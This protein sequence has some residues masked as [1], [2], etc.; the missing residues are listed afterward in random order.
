LGSIALGDLL[1]SAGSILRECREAWQGAFLGSLFVGLIAAAFSHFTRWP[2]SVVTLTAIMVLVPRASAILGV[3][4]A[5]SSGLQAGLHA[6]WR[7]F[8]GDSRHHRST[9]GRQK[10]DA[11]EAGRVG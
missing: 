6:E 7:T 3:K 11:A 4:T 2:A 10:P 5:Q 8:V 1:P 9:S